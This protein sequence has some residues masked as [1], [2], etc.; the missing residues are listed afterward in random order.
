M[1]IIFKPSEMFILKYHLISKYQK[2]QKK[3][4]HQRFT[5]NSNFR[6]SYPLL[7]PDYMQ[8]VRHIKN[9]YNFTRW[10]VFGL[11]MFMIVRNGFSGF[12]VYICI[13]CI[14]VP[15]Q[16]QHHVFDSVLVIVSTS[17]FGQRGRPATS[18][19]WL[20]HSAWISK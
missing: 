3:I 18:G 13:S 20:S 11:R 10:L 6:I 15:P 19:A 1:L 5:R 2:Y 7:I 12:L 16:Y 8:L 4:S 17:S 14:P 9:K